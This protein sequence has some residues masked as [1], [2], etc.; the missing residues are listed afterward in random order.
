MIELLGFLA[1]LAVF[2]FAWGFAQYSMLFPQTYPHVLQPIDALLLAFHQMFVNI[3]SDVTKGE[4]FDMPGDDNECIND[5]DLYLN[6]T[7]VRCT[8]RPATYTTFIF[9]SIY[10]LLTNLLL[11]NLLIAIFSTTYQKIEGSTSLILKHN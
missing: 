5:P 10:L 1:I 8:D 9:M 7:A 11:F 2:V 3:Y 6:H 4:P